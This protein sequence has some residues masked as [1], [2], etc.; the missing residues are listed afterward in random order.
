VAHVVEMGFYG[1]V[2]K[3][4]EVTIYIYIYIYGNEAS[5]D[6]LDYCTSLT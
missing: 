4:L 3:T 6:R 1:F 2:S 5:P